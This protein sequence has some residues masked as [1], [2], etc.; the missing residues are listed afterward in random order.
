MATLVY[1]KQSITSGGSFIFNAFSAITTPAQTLVLLTPVAYENNITINT[2]SKNTLDGTAFS[3]TFSGVNITITKSSNA[4]TEFTINYQTASQSLTFIFTMESAPFLLMSCPTNI[5]YDGKIC[6]SGGKITIVSQ[7]DA[8]WPTTSTLYNASGAK[9]NITTVNPS[10][11]NWVTYKEDGY[12]KT[13]GSHYNPK[14]SADSPFTQPTIDIAALKIIFY[15]RLTNNTLMGNARYDENGTKNYSINSGAFTFDLEITESACLLKGT[16]IQ[17]VDGDM[18]IETIQKDDILIL[19][20]GKKAKVINTTFEK[21]HLTNP[22][23]LYCIEKNT[24]APNVPCQDTFLSPKHVFGYKGKLYHPEHLTLKGLYKCTDKVEFELYNLELE[25]YL[26]GLM[27]ANGL[28]VETKLNSKKINKDNDLL[29]V[30]WDCEYKNRV[31]VH[32]HD[33]CK[34]ILFHTHRNYFKMESWKPF[35]QEAKTKTWQ[36]ITGNKMVMAGLTA[37]VSVFLLN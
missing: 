30:N 9:I 32:V 13:D 5:N 23:D 24:F 21:F 29:S 15:Q 22:I 11:N 31:G 4:N 3:A 19:S 1:G 37:M 36:K 34:L 8:S 16:M 25:N 28:E 35:L 7:T 33:D 2:I 6:K 10:I 12:E 20:N 14:Q 17:T 27:I 26:D 18:P